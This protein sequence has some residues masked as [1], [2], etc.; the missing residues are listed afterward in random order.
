MIIDPYR[1]G[2]GSEGGTVVL[3]MHM[4]GADNGSTF[5]DSSVYAHTPTAYGP[6][7]ST[8]WAK[9]GATSARIATGGSGTERIAIPN[10]AAFNTGTG[11]FTIE[12]WVRLTT[13]Q[14]CFFV[15]KSVGNSYFP[16]RVMLSN[17]RLRFDC[18]TNS[19]ANFP[20]CTGATTFTTGVDYFVQ[21]RRR[22]TAQANYE[23]AL[24]GT[25][26]GSINDDLVYGTFDN[27]DVLRI[28]NGGNNN[29]PV[30]GY[31]DDLRIS[32]GVARSFAVPSGTLADS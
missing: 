1:F 11:E 2:A 22:N 30:L 6:I 31:M 5:T 20:V 24:N 19:G 14:D 18:Y 23:V 10:N 17:S 28:G 25:I 12:F 13:L 7:T 21:A 4:E 3:S 32:T 8:G 27:T 26:D 9:Y 29:A 16:W 15:V